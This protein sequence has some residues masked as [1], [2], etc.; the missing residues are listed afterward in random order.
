MITIVIAEDDNLTARTL[1]HYCAEAFEN[2]PISVKHFNRLT[3][4]LYFVQENPIDLLLLDI[5]LKG[6]SGFDIL[7]LPEK[8]SYYTIIISSD[9]RNAVSAFDFGVLDFIA[10]PFT[11]ER[12]MAAIGRMRDARGV[13]GRQ[14]NSLSIKKDGM[15]EIV[16]YKDI[17][18]LQAVGNFTDLHL[19]NGQVERMR[20]TLDSV[21]E[22]LNSDFFRSHRSYI[23]NLA[24]V[25]SIKRGKNNT[26]SV[27]INNT[28]ATEVPLSRSNYTTLKKILD[29]PG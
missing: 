9:T 18:F 15:L 28:A 10:K 4:A 6:E 2:E 14:K 27:I 11:R 7:E 24:W 26:Y 19:Q 17:L 23:I 29:D 21:L 5:N 12:F 8:D 20:R 22:N 16:K 13:G 1:R 25:Q 3:P